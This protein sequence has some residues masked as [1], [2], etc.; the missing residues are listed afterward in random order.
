MR[1]GAIQTYKPIFTSVKKT[2]RN[3][4]VSRPDRFEKSSFDFD[5]ECDIFYSKLEKSMG[6]VTPQDIVKQANNVSKKTGVGLDSVYYAMGLLSQ[7]SSYKSLQDIESALSYREI[8]SITALPYEYMSESIPV[9]NV[10][11]YICGKNLRIKGE[12]NAI[13]V[14]SNL[15]N[16]VKNMDAKGRKNFFDYI[17]EFDF[18]LLYFD[19]FENGYNFFNQE[20]SFENYTIDVIKKAQKFQKHNDKNLSYNIR[21]VLNGENYKNMKILSGGGQIEVIKHVNICTPEKI[22][23]N[24]NPIMPSKDEFKSVINEISNNKPDAQKDILKF[25][26]RTLTVV[27][28]KQY[29]KYFHNIHKQLLEYLKE[30]GKTMDD[31]YFIIPSVTKSFMPANYVYTKVNHIENPK[32]VFLSEDYLSR[33]DEVESLP[34][35][36]VAVVV[37][38][39]VLSGLSMKEEVFPYIELSD[40]GSKN[41][42]IVFAPSVAINAGKRELERIA[43]I[44]NRDDKFICGKLLPEFK[45]NSNNLTIVFDKATKSHLTTSVVFPYMGPDFNCDELVPLYGKFLYNELA[46]KICIG[47]INENTMLF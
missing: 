4:F 41:K 47:E 6:V 35:N 25:L 17:K 15:I 7:Y 21:Y 20:K 9:S 22:A 37:D 30:H 29:G 40:T 28:P 8:C 2:E 31:V 18:K 5:K 44:K 27:T 32:Y 46:Q 19:N 43:E 3:Q 34:K 10:M 33:A 13:M 12:N 24:L 42:N 38:D 1:V 14:D 39:C 16:T 45:I 11:S 36:A 23:D 26:D